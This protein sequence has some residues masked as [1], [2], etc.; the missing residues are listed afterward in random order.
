MFQKIKK[1]LFLGHF[2][3]NFGMNE[4]P[5]LFLNIPIIYHRAK[6]YKK[7]MSHT[8]ENARQT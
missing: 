8:L 4:F 3:P 2:C 6:N 7:L 5:C 1:T